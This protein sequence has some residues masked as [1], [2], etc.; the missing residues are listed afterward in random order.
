MTEFVDAKARDKI[1][2][3]YEATL[4]VEAAAGT[5]KTTVLVATMPV[6]LTRQACERMGGR[7]GVESKPGRGSR[8]WIELPA[9]A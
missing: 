8:F 1:L 5:G 9:A 3:D 6:A 2:G 7:T 4:F